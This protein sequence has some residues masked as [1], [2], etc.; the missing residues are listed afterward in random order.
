[1][2]TKIGMALNCLLHDAQKSLKIVKGNDH[3]K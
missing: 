2:K 3:R 1:M